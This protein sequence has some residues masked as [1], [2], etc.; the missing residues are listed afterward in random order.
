MASPEVEVN[1]S[2]PGKYTGKFWLSIDKS[3]CAGCSICVRL[4]PGNV[5]E[6]RGEDNV[7]KK[8]LHSVIVNPEGCLYCGKCIDKCPCN[9]VVRI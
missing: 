1:F 2:G 7:G 8:L 3:K 4:C 6:I 9:A 5:F